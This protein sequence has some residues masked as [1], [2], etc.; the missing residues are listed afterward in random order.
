MAD[1]ASTLPDKIEIGATRRFDWRTSVVETDAGT[2][3]RNNRWANPLRVY[4]LNFP[5]MEIDDADYL[6]V[7]ALY[8]E[9]QGGLLSFEFTD[10]SDDSVVTVRFAGE[11]E[12]A[13]PNG[14]H[15]KIVSVVL[16]EVR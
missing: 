4:E 16:K 1:L 13:A 7:L 10:W 5:V 11:L 14:G 6:A 15:R 2:E 9:A 8:D 3:I 12:E